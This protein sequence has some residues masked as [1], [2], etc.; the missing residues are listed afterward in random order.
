MK[1]IYLQRVKVKFCSM[2]M[3][4]LCPVPLILFIDDYAFF[5]FAKN[6]RKKYSLNI[7]IGCD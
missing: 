2:P 1:K 3:L 6:R 7:V 4:F 5:S